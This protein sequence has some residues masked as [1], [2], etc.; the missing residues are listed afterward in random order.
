MSRPVNKLPAEAVNIENKVSFGPLDVILMSAVST[1]LYLFDNYGQ[2][3]YSV[4]IGVFI[5][6]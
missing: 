3:L 4:Y 2:L 5:P 1:Y 6:V